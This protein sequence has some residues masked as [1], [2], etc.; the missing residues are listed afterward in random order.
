VSCFGEG[1]SEAEQLGS[2]F[3]LLSCY[4]AG[5]DGHWRSLAEHNGI[6][7]TRSMSEHRGERR[8]TEGPRDRIECAT[9]RGVLALPDR[10]GIISALGFPLAS[11]W[12]VKGP[13]GR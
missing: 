7:N 4:E 13:V 11:N 6:V 3:G 8:A 9:E 5:L 1:A 12:A 2:R 10:R